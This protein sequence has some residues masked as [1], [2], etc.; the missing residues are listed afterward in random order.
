MSAM[1]DAARLTDAVHTFFRLNSTFPLAS[2]LEDKECN[3]CYEPYCADH[4]SECEATPVKLRCGHVFCLGCATTWAKDAAY[5]AL[6]KCPMCRQP[7]IS[8]IQ[9]YL[10]NVLGQPKEKIIEIA[11]SWSRESFIAYFD[12]LAFLRK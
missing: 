7:Y 12:E 8:Q 9:A 6:P 5:P 10:F 2:T 11:E 4:A 1:E 3:I